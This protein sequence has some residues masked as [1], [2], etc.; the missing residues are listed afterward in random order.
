MKMQYY[1]DFLC[2][3]HL[4]DELWQAFVHEAFGVLCGDHRELEVPHSLFYVLFFVY[5]REASFVLLQFTPP[6]IDRFCFPE[7]RTRNEKFVE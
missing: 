7:G 6:Q 5:W 1:R 2:S 3:K 4:Y